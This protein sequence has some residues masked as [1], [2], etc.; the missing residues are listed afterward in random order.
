MIKRIQELKS[1]KSNHI[2]VK[3]SIKQKATL[4]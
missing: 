2:E 4:N 3:H 1:D